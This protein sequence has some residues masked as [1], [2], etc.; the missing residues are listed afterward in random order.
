MKDPKGHGSNSTGAHAGFIQNLPK[1]MGRRHFEQIAE[2]LRSA[3]TSDPA[4]HYGRLE[5]MMNHLATTNPNFNR[6]MFAK[7]AT[8]GD[9]DYKNRS[10]RTVTRATASK[11][12]KKF[13]T[14]FKV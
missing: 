14:S 2:T 4:G 1:K 11:Q 3:A 7:A 9:S 10:T 13:T 6:E 5:A 12:L 8:P